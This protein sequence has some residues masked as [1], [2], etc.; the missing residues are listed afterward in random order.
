M[1]L[2]NIDGVATKSSLCCEV[3]AHASVAIE[4]DV[5]TSQEDA[6]PSS[7]HGLTCAVGLKNALRLCE[8]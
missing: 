4:L 5:W 8:R 3:E 2:R 7:L 6:L 1:Y